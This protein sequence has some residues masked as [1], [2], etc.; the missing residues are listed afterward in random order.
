MTIIFRTDGAWGTGLGVNLNPAQV[1]GN[2]WDLQGRL[3]YIE[4]NPV[5]PIEP[6]SITISGSQFS[7]GLSNGETLGPITMTMP[8][9]LWLRRLRSGMRPPS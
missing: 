4:D 6:I 8:V 2:F 1:D 7:M 3:T 9:P 5:E